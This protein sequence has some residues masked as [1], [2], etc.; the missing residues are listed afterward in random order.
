MNICLSFER[1]VIMKIFLTILIL[2]LTKSTHQLCRSS[3]GITTCDN[4]VLQKNVPLRVNDYKNLLQ[5]KG[6]YQSI[7]KGTFKLLTELKTLYISFDNVKN[8]EDGSF[9]GLYNLETLSLYSNQLEIINDGVFRDCRNL[10]KLNLGSNK[11]YEIESRVFDDT[12]ILSELDLRFNDLQ[13]IPGALAK[14]KSLELLN[15]SNNKLK[16]VPFNSFNNLNKLQVLDLSDNQIT[17]LEN[18]ALSGLYNLKELN[19][20]SNYLRNL[21]TQD[22]SGDLQ[23]LATIKLSI[24]PFNCQTLKN[25]VDALESKGVAVAEGFSKSK[26]TVRGMGCVKN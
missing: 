5:L 21:N 2:V 11:I 24:N 10:K 3:V 4:E 20:K 12:V 9:Q 7:P 23:K 25:I 13:N 6:N 16:S 22:F 1:L 26:D 18:G 14:L 17:T 15:L 8:L 19:L